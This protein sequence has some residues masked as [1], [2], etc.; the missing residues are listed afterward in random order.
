MLSDCRQNRIRR[1]CLSCIPGLSSRRTAD[2]SLW[3]L[4]LQANMAESKKDPLE[5]AYEQLLNKLENFKPRPYLNPEEVEFC[6]D[7]TRT[8]LK[9]AW[10]MCDEGYGKQ[11]KLDVH[12]LV[13]SDARDAIRTELSDPNQR[14]ETQNQDPIEL[15]R[16]HSTATEIWAKREERTVTSCVMEG[17]LRGLSDEGRWAHPADRIGRERIQNPSGS[18]P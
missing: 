3:F 14:A 16:G 10:G 12:D 7:I 18:D 6:R 1:D 2:V 11:P 9:A 13:G 17:L 8:N 4:D 5:V 15:A